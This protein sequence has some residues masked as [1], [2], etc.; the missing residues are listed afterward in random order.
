MRYY[1]ETKHQDRYTGLITMQDGRVMEYKHVRG[2]NGLEPYLM[3][4]ETGEVYP[5][6]VVV[7]DGETEIYVTEV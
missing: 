2:P 6:V 7:S 1:F 3:D 5:V 4:T